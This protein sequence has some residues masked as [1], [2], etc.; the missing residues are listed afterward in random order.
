MNGDTQSS[1]PMLPPPIHWVLRLNGR[2]IPGINY[3]QRSVVTL[4][5]MASQG[6]QVP[7]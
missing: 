7:L 3:K 4:S 6:A 5:P 1:A 2:L